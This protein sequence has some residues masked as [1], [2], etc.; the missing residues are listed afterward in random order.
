MEWTPELK[1]RAAIF[2]A[3]AMIGTVFAIALFNWAQDNDASV[4][5]DRQVRV[6]LA[7]CDLAAGDELVAECVEEREVKSRF[8]P[9]Q[10]L[11]AQDLDW[12]LGRR[13]E[14]A[15]PKG[16]ALRTVDF[17]PATSEQARERA[18]D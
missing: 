13:L 17:E 14:V 1:R 6:V 4:V 16:S 12:H 18:A 7:A 3:G 5:P 9:P 11:M 2:G 10:T 15:V 8:A